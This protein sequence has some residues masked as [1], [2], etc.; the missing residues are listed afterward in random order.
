MA[1]KKKP[2]VVI[3]RKLPDQ[4]ET[5]MRELFEARQGQAAGTELETGRLLRID[6]SGGLRFLGGRRHGKQC[7]RSG[8]SHYP[9]QCHRTHPYARTQ[10]FV[11]TPDLGRTHQKQAISSFARLG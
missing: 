1:G 2:L 6:P 5:R 8:A 11:L 10:H 4:V 3:T 9:T 7:R